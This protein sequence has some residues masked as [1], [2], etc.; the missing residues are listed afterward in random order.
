MRERIAYA[1]AVALGLVLV[2]ACALIAWAR[3]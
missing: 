1:A 3:S 2:A